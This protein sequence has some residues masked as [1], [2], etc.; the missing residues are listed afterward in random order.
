MK[1]S[2]QYIFLGIF[3]GTLPVSYWYFSAKQTFFKEVASFEACVKA[4]F[5]ILSVY[6][7]VCAMPGKQFVN[8]NQ[9]EQE[10][11]GSAEIT[12]LE[13]SQKIQDAYKNLQY[14]ID[15]QNIQFLDGLGVLPSNML[16]RRATSALQLSS[17]YVELNSS[18]KPS[19]ALSCF[20]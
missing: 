13:S 9:K 1:I 7:E 4:G 2:K 3:L 8:N 16:L 19:L 6:P 14:Y 12:L 15:G 10:S 11:H 17:T 20:F 18:E 5:P